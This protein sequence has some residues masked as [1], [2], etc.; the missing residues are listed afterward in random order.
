MFVTNYIKKQKTNKQNK[1]KKDLFV[2]LQKLYINRRCECIAVYYRFRHY[3]YDINVQRSNQTLSGCYRKLNAE[4]AGIDIKSN[5]FYPITKHNR[6]N[7][8][9]RHQQKELVCIIP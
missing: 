3:A 8:N 1:Q 2:F 5:A 7:V 6:Q 4:L 9:R